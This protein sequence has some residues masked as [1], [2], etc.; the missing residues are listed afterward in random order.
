MRA[1]V[2][3]LVLAAGIAHADSIN[4]ELTHEP[5]PRNL[6]MRPR[7][8]AATKPEPSAAPAPPP[9]AEVSTTTPA[10]DTADAFQIRDLR[11]PISVR[12]NLGYVVDGAALT[13]RPNLSEH[14]VGQHEF[15]QLRAY[16]LGEGYFSSRGVVLPSLSTYFAARFQLMQRQLKVNPDDMTGARV[17]VAPPI[18]NWFDRSGFELRSGWAE[19]QDFLPSKRLSLLRL[20]A[21][22]SSCGSTGPRSR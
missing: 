2:V 19:V 6:R 15:A 7:T 5:P 16:A 17:E 10:S 21:D 12:F 18:A 14:T 1:V 11:R 22:T 8:A 13:G 3:T 4:L 9:E 20:R